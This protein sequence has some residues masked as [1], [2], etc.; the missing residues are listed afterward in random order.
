MSDSCSLCTISTELY[1]LQLML[2]VFLA[3][4]LL[5]SRWRVS[6]LL[7]ELSPDAATCLWSDVC[8]CVCAW[9]QNVID[10]Y[11]SLQLGM[12][13]MTCLPG[14]WISHNTTQRWDAEQQDAC[15]AVLSVAGEHFAGTTDV[16]EWQKYTDCVQTRWDRRQQV[17]LVYCVS[18][19]WPSVSSASHCHH[20]SDSEDGFHIFSSV[21]HKVHYNSYQTVHSGLLCCPIV[22]CAV[23]GE[24]GEA[25]VLF[26]FFFFFQG[27][28]YFL[29]FPQS[30]RSEW[31]SAEQSHPDKY[32]IRQ[33]IKYDYLPLLSLWINALINDLWRWFLAY[34]KVFNHIT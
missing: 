13:C 7:D 16:C 27:I 3:K 33:L 19:F 22:I 2:L 17:L 4:R 12:R 25:T 18:V 30:D 15:K 28:I 10:W 14:S 1:D 8:V 31:V 5:P 29:Q 20:H 23:F 9:G 6:T 21:I 11:F 32:E 24:H 34:C 26:F